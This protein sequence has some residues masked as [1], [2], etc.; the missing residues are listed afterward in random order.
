MKSLSNHLTTMRNWIFAIVVLSLVTCKKDNDVPADELNTA[1]QPTD[2]IVAPNILV[3]VSD[4][5]APD[6][7][8]SAVNWP[9]V[10][11]EQPAGGRF[12]VP[13]GFGNL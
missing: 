5:P 9:Q 4:L 6:P 13:Q 10:L 1:D 11:K 2:V 7:T 3:R 12:Q 8:S